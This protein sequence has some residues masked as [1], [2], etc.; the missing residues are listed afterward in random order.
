M[1]GMSGRELA[2]RL[3]PLH[4]ETAVLFTSGYTEDMVVLRG[5]MEEN[6]HF[7]GKPYTIPAIVRKVRQVLDARP[8]RV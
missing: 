3:Q 8:P 6:L 1:P 5:V 2:E 7:I 4:P